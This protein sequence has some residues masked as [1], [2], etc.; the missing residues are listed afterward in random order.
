MGSLVLNLVNNCRIILSSKG[1]TIDYY[2]K[3][4]VKIGEIF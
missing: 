1:N 4:S 3:E 2:K